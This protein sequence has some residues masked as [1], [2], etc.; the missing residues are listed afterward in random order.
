MGLSGVFLRKCRAIACPSQIPGHGHWAG[1]VQEKLALRKKIVDWHGG[2]IWCESEFGHGSRFHVELAP[3]Q[4]SGRRRPGQKD[5]PDARLHKSADIDQ[6][7][8]LE[9]QVNAAAF[10]FIALDQVRRIR[11][12]TNLA[13]DRIKRFS[14]HFFQCRPSLAVGNPIQLGV[15][16][17]LQHTLPGNQ[18]QD[19]NRTEQ[20]HTEPCRRAPLWVKWRATF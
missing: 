18:P 8:V 13:V 17:I 5:V 10:G 7:V 6:A 15:D 20:Q 14:Q 4:N 19:N 1:P 2:R 3:L 16:P 11:T 12:A 9:P